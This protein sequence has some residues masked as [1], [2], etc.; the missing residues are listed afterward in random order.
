MY[1]RYH[2][3]IGSLSHSESEE[4]SMHEVSDTVLAL[5][6]YSDPLFSVGIFLL[7]AYKRF[8]EVLGHDTGGGG[9]TAIIILSPMI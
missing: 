8:R 7:S 3:I 4:S 2:D 9:T 6:G 1:T 5:L